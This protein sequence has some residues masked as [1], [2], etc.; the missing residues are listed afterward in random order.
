MEI[1]SIQNSQYNPYESIEQA[2]KLTEQ[3]IQAQNVQKEK[4]L[5]T[6]IALKTNSSQEKEKQGIIDEYAWFS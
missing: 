2:N 1:S 6:E 3:I 4:E 5:A